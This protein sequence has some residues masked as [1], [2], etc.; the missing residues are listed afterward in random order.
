MSPFGKRYMADI[1]HFE[2]GELHRPIAF[3]GLA[4]PNEAPP[5]SSI[6]YWLAYWVAAFEHLLTERADVV[7]V[8]YER[9]CKRGAASLASVEERA[10]LEAGRLVEAA[11]GRLR[12][13]T[14]YDL[15][16][17]VHDADTL[18]RARSA[19]E[20]LLVESVV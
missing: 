17:E 5:T 4:G 12:P 19:H 7:F 6:D 1:G 14:A 3:P 20:R 13:P 2:F 18:S 10:G 9:M 8:S 11:Q 15:E 16:G